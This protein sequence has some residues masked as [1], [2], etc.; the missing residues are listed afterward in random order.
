MG[1]LP[2]SPWPIVVIVIVTLLL[3]AA[4]KLPTTTRSLAKSARIIR[5]EAKEAKDDGNSA[6]PNVSDASVGPDSETLSRK[7]ELAIHTRT[8]IQSSPKDLELAK[9]QS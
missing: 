7:P 9:G 5:S 3:F 2:D 6:P 4:P 1:R 8:A